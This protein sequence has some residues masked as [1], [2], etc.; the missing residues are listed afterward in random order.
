MCKASIKLEDEESLTG[1]IGLNDHNHGAAPS[2]RGAE[3]GRQ[4][5]KEKMRENPHLV[6]S[7]LRAQVRAGVDDEVFL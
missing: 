5:M 2:R 4:E 3:I 7:R 1:S 6:P